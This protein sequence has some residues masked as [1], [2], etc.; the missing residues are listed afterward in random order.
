MKKRTLTLIGLAALVGITGIGFAAWNYNEEQQT[1]DSGNPADI[2]LAGADSFVAKYT[3]TFDSNGG[4][5]VTAQQVYN[6]GYATLPSEPTYAGHNFTHWYLSTGSEDTAFNFGTTQITGAIT[7]K[8]KWLAS[9]T[10]YLIVFDTDGGSHV[11]YQEVASGSY[12]TRPTNP[13]KTSYDFL[14]WYIRTDITETEFDFE[15][16]PITGRVELKAKW[17][18]THT[19]A[20]FV[21]GKIY[22]DVQ[23]VRTGGT[24]TLPDSPSKDGYSFDGW[25]I[26]G[27]ET[28]FTAASVINTNTVVDAVFTVD[29]PYLMVGSTRYNMNLYAK[30]SPTF[31]EHLAVVDLLVATTA[32]VHHGDFSG[33]VSLGIGSN[34]VLYNVDGAGGLGWA[35]EGHTYVITRDAVVVGAWAEAGAWEGVDSTLR[36][37]F[38]P[39]NIVEMMILNVPITAG[40]TWKVYDFTDATFRNVWCTSDIKYFTTAANGNGSMILTATFNMYM[41]FQLSSSSEPEALVWVENANP[42][43][44][45]T[46][47]FKGNRHEAWGVNWDDGGAL[48]YMHIWGAASGDSTWPGFLMPFA[49]GS[50]EYHV[51]K[52]D[53]MISNYT[54]L[55]FTRRDPADVTENEW[56]RFNVAN[57]STKD[58]GDI[59][60]PTNMGNSYLIAGKN[61]TWAEYEILPAPVL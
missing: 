29:G 42:D 47:Y 24:A 23:F 44:V 3:V 4:S 1:T 5:A 6:G 25:I 55:L 57:P 11:D 51:F 48:T 39:A 45:K 30:S 20:F 53:S 32:T 59:A 16:T 50:T 8:A 15:N 37:S 13:T 52:Y 12:A 22:G 36:L 38:N 43:A 46:I 26:R 10:M 27:T 49:D 21:D 7:L 33:E 9:T 41:T 61:D 60:I 58:G 40:L 31:P 54:T 28:A 35:N 14:Y 56:G 17:I 34:V 19:V 2:G 18:P